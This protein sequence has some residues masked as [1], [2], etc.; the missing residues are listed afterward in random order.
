MIRESAGSDIRVFQPVCP[1]MTRQLRF[2]IPRREFVDGT[3]NCQF[4][5]DTDLLWLHSS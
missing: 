1:Q 5:V 3:K 2:L 4:A